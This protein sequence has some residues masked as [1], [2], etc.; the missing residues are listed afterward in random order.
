MSGTWQCQAEVDSPQG[1]EAGQDGCGDNG[2]G[3]IFGKPQE[4]MFERTCKDTAGSQ[5]AEVIRAERTNR[6][7]RIES[8]KTTGRKEGRKYAGNCA[9]HQKRESPEDYAHS[10][11]SQGG[12]Q[13]RP[14]ELHLELVMRTEQALR[15]DRWTLRP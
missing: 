9:R 10:A 11:K 3:A 13:R 5:D 4:R 2:G 1:L 14:T 15:R 6:S 7:D 12:M 8:L